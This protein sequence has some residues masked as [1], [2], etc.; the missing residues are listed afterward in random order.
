VLADP[1]TRLADGYADFCRQAPQ[2]LISPPEAR[3]KAC[4]IWLV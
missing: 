2:P 3:H 1:L 4:R